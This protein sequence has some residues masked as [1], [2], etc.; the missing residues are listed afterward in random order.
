MST[1]AKALRF[2][3][4]WEGGF[5]DDPDDRGGRTNK[6]VTQRVYNKW[7]ENQSQPGKDVL[8]I[9]DNEVSVIYEQNYWLRAKCDRLRDSLDM[10]QFDTAINMGVNRAIKILQQAVGAD[11]DGRFGPNTQKACD[12]CD[13]GTALI[14]YCDIREGLYRRFATVP[15]QAKFLKGWMNRL[16]DLRHTLGLPGFES[17]L[18]DTE[19]VSADAPRINDLGEGENL[20]NWQ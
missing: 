1:Y 15:R 11:V 16:N 12:D 14:M 9:S 10:A 13:I 7:L 3:L 2:V 4:R 5:V 19:I 20:E 18:D 6:G 8:N 17:T